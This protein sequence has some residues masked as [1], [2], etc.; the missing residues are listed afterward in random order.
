[1]LRF[2]CVASVTLAAFTIGCGTDEPVAATLAVRGDVPATT[3]RASYVAGGSIGQV[4]VTDAKEGDELVLVDA[5]SNEVGRGTAD[6]L[7]SFLWRNVD[8]GPGYT[9]RSIKAD[10]VFGTDPFVVLSRGDVPDA[11]LYDQELAP[12]INYVKMRDGIELAMTVRLPTGKTMADAPFPTVIEYSGY[13]VAAPGDLLAAATAAVASGA[14]L[15]SLD[16]P[17]LPATSTAVGSLILP[18]VG[19]AVVSVQMR[20]SG[21]SGGDFQLFDVPTTYDGYDAV[22]V[23]AAQPWVKGGKVGLAGSRSPASR[24][25]SSAARA[26]RTS[27]RSPR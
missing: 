5:A 3:V 25:C 11:K 18:M 19:Y 21:C 20:G 24:S 12:G 10:K 13:Q 17:L 8:P 22:E 23:T 16:D 9:V 27:P 26:R 2:G 7:G 6:R 14:G 15:G 4:W 1:M